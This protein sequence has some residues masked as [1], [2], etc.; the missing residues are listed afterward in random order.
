M[1]TRIDLHLLLIG[2]CCLL[3]AC[4]TP[5]K[6][7]EV[8][9]PPWQNDLITAVQMD[10]VF[11]LSQVL[12]KHALPSDIALNPNGVTPLMVASSLGCRNVVQWLLSNGAKAN[13]PTTLKA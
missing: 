7:K 3:A 13:A 2:A 5:Q 11:G 8:E 9:A 4:A 10:D 1:K 12:A 6:T